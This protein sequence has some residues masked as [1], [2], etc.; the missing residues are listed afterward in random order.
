M[1]E[2]QKLLG[3]F[4]MQIRGNSIRI[5]SKC[6]GSLLRG[7][8]SQNESHQRTCSSLEDGIVFPDGN[9]WKKIISAGTGGDQ[10]R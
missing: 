3:E 6:V 2:G 5:V 4:S 9:K 10:I 1:G 8:P 7:R